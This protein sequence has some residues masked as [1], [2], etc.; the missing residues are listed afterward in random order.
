MVP[1]KTR[2]LET[3]G[4]AVDGDDPLR[5]D[6]TEEDIDPRHRHGDGTLTQTDSDEK[7]RLAD[8]AQGG[9]VA[10]DQAEPNEFGVASREMLDKLFAQRGALR[11]L[12]VLLGC[13]ALLGTFFGACA[14]NGRTQARL[15]LE[16]SQRQVYQLQADLDSLRRKTQDNQRLLEETLETTQADLAITQAINRGYHALYV[17]KMPAWAAQAFTK[18]LTLSRGRA[19]RYSPSWTIYGPHW[20]PEVRTMFVRE[21]RFSLENDYDGPYMRVDGS[22]ELPPEPAARATLEVNVGPANVKAT[23]GH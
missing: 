12:T 3:D 20:P 2:M 23:I 19:G 16:S 10:A 4:T 17:A 5:K 21:F 1:I 9:L 8:E 15:E 14:V 11:V 22:P 7:A 18:A 6:M 13:L